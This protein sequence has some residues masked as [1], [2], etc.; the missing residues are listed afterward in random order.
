MFWN[1]CEILRVIDLKSSLVFSKPSPNQTNL[2]IQQSLIT[3]SVVSFEY[4]P[5]G[6]VTSGGLFAAID[7]RQNKSDLVRQLI[8]ICK[9]W[10]N[11]SQVIYRY[12]QWEEGKW[13]VGGS[14]LS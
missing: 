9:P 6:H 5:C 13:T 11:S 12:T 4:R 10:G 8:Y 7:P 3:Y 2:N 14:A 1:R